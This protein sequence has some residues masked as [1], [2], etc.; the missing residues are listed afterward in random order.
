[1]SDKKPLVIGNLTFD[2]PFLLA[3]LAG[4]SDKS[5][6]SLC[7]KHGA[8]LTFTE[9]VSAKGL[10]YG[11]QK[12]KDLLN[13]GDSETA[14]GYQLFGHEPEVIANAMASL[15][16]ND[17]L[18]FDLNS[19]CPVPKVVKNGEGSALL[20]TLDVLGDVV[21][22]MVKSTDKP[23]TVKFRMGFARGEDT[24]VET[25]KI[26]EAAGASAITIHGRTR[27]Q[28]YEGAANWDAI[29]NVK[30]AVSIPVI[31]N[32][33]V[34]CGAD[35][36]RMMDETGCDGV[37]IARG[38][39]GNPWIFTECI[40]LWNG[41][42]DFRGPSRS[43]KI[44]MLL[45]HFALIRSDKGDRVAVKEIRKH[46]GWYLKGMRG[47][48]QVKREMSCINDSSELIN[49]LTKLKNGWN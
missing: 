4:I 38:A 30:K 9:M 35:A 28:Y 11:G 18:L 41:E 33:D 42:T 5:M 49:K 34:Q 8:S 22:T 14:V 15:R 48:S 27:E 21:E 47:A 20:K 16:D 19:G 2:N 10:T 1:M 12:S 44:D 25:A 7:A 17:N 32:G 26:L 3:P 6:R 24:A 46:I 13:I 23:V 37:M 43:D 39:L 36:M 45:H 29:A 31:G 40:K